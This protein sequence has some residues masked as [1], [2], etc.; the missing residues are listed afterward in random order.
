MPVPSSS[1]LARRR[2]AARRRYVAQDE[3]VGRAH[4]R[5]ILEARHRQA[6]D[7]REG[8]HAGVVEVGAVG[9][10]AVDGDLDDAEAAQALQQAEHVALVHR[11]SA[12]P[13]V[14]RVEGQDACA[15]GAR[16]SVR[17]GR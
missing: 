8:A 10:A 9:A 11:S 1:H 7:D 5:K 16:A 17:R 15:G 12:Q 3:R 4:V 14:G 6:G 2:V 13:A